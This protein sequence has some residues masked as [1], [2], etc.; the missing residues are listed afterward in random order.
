MTFQPDCPVVSGHFCLRIVPFS[1]VL[2]FKPEKGEGS[3]HW[4][5][6][7]KPSSL[8]KLM[9]SKRWWWCANQRILTLFVFVK[10]ARE[11]EIHLVCRICGLLE[12][13]DDCFIVWYNRLMSLKRARHCLHLSLPS[14]PTSSFSSQF[15]SFHFP[16]LPFWG[17]NLSGWASTLP[18]NTFYVLQILRF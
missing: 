3:E 18:R 12:P 6:M 9:F 15:P 17:C 2:T 7:P 16:F 10:S 11:S 4:V 14:L 1:F 13:L 8:F 5:S